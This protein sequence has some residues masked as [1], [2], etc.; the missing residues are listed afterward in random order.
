M[1]I[2][3]KPV[4][5]RMMRVVAGVVDTSTP[6]LDPPLLLGLTH[7]PCRKRVGSPALRILQDWQEVA[8]NCEKKKK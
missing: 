6:L 1:Y 5:N 7:I 8:R 4:F 3:K 2:W